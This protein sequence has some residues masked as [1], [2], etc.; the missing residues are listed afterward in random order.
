MFTDKMEGK[1]FEKM[2]EEDQEVLARVRK[3]QADCESGGPHI[4]VKDW[5][6]RAPTA[7]DQYKVARIASEEI[8][9]YRKIATLVNELG[10]EPSYS[11]WKPKEERDVDAF[12]ETMPNWAHFA[13]FGFLIDRVGHYQLQEFYECSYLPL[14]R[15]L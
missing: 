7:D 10:D 5:L 8:D 13:M 2:P 4:Y 1:D 11:L 12:K 15:I 9:H 14:A 3:I 6:L